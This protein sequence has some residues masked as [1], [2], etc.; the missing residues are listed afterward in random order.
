VNLIKSTKSLL[1]LV[2]FSILLVG[3]SQQQ[4]VQG[5]PPAEEIKKENI[6]GIIGPMTE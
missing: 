6:V 1:L 5:E 3:C 2:A 4:E